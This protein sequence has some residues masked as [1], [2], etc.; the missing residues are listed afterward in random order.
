[1]ARSWTSERLREML[2]Q[3]VEAY[4]SRLGALE[5][6]S[7]REQGV[8]AGPSSAIDEIDETATDWAARRL[9]D[10]FDEEFGGF[11]HRAEDA[12]H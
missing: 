7:D 12:T 10:E 3:V 5:Q 1:M 8:A 6:A 11:R 9:A 2:P 4:G